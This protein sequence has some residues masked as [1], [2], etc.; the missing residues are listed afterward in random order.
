MKK[1]NKGFIAISL[2]YSFFLVFLVTLLSTVATYAQN[3]I[4]LND[5]KKET[6]K[7]LN[8]LAEFNPVNLAHKMDANGNRINYSLGE[9]V[10]VASEIWN[11]VEDYGDTTK[12]VLKRNLT[13]NE[14]NSALSEANITGGGLNDT[15]L[16][17]LNVYTPQICNYE[18]NVVYNEY[19]YNLSLVKLILEHWFINNAILQKALDTGNLV[20]Q[21]FTDGRSNYNAYIRI[22]LS[23]EYDKI[24]DATA[25]YLTFNG[26]TN[27]ISYIN[28]ND[29][30]IPA[31]STYKKIRPIIVI[32]KA[33]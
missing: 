22:P 24:N 12:L 18:S 32:K 31:H 14:I 19:K 10:S 30:S 9:E 6:Q 20:N 13:A 25:W 4:L 21:S 8:N 27:G 17:C 1:N 16:M 7:Y 3:R 28:I 15:T 5:V 23:D 11:V 2:I 26:I 29:T 33:N